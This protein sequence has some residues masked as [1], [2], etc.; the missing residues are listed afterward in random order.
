M[1][2]STDP[3]PTV[4]VYIRSPSREGGEC[5]CLSW[6]NLC[7]VWI[8]RR[9][10][11]RHKYFMETLVTRIVRAHYFRHDLTATKPIEIWDAQSLQ[12]MV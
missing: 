7:S 3:R 9:I 1:S 4:V 11:H 6:R 2:M 12:I 5:V 8:I 10:Y